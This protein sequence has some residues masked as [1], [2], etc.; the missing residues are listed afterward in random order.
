MR[1]PEWDYVRETL[2]SLRV[3][4]LRKLG[5][6]WFSGC[7]GGASTKAGIVQEMASQMRYW[8]HL[9]NGVGRTRVASVIRDME[10]LKEEKEERDGR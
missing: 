2:T 4:D 10:K 6:N 7:L 9:T 5:R 1:E 8:W 3:K